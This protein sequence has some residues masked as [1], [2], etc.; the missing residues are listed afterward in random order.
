MILKFLDNSKETASGNSK[1]S[2]A[3]AAATKTVTTSSVAAAAAGAGETSVSAANA[4][5]HDLVN[6][7]EDESGS[8]VVKV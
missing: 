2:G 7:D 5:K 1:A 3:E 6:K 8:F 4:A